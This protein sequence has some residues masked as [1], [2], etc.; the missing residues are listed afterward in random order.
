MKTLLL[1]TVLLVQGSPEG[2]GAAD[3]HALFRAGRFAEAQSAFQ[4]ALDADPEDAEIA[5]NLALAAWRAGDAQTAEVAAEKAA[6]LS[7]GRFAPLRDGLLGNLRYEA[8]RQAVEG[9]PAQALESARAA[10]DHFLRGA[11]DDPGNAALKRNLERAQRLLDALEAQAQQDSPQQEPEPQD[12]AED[13]SSEDA[14][15]Q[16][17]EDAK[18]EDAKSEAAKPEDEPAQQEPPSEEPDQRPSEESKP[19]ESK[20]EKS[21][22]DESKPDEAQDPGREERDP[23]GG[24]PEGESGAEP[25]EPQPEQSEG[26]SPEPQPEPDPSGAAGEGADPAAEPDPA[27]LD[28]GAEPP[29]GEGRSAHA[30]LPGE[31]DPGKALSAE[32]VTRLLQALRQ[33]EE[34]RDEARAR[35]RERRAPVKQD[36]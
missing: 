10:R 12:G 19:D 22:P 4:A 30:P 7:G 23:K 18:P 36:W 6:T 33:L 24:E 14:P 11:L 26:E 3:G 20:P 27:D 5:W 21:K 28:P 8:A 29:A 13:E 17:P 16:Q 15:Q 25:P 2:A 9:D 32:Q 1:C 31:G 34:L 35:S